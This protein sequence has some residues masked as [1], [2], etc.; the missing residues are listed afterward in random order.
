[1][2]KNS[3][4]MSVKRVRE[5][6]GF[7]YLDSSN[8]DES[9]VQGLNG[10]LKSLLM[11]HKNLVS[12]K[13]GILS[14]DNQI[15]NTIKQLYIPMKI[16][17][18]TLD[19]INKRVKEIL[20]G[21]TPSD[22][23]IFKLV[24]DTKVD[25]Y[26]VF[27]YLKVKDVDEFSNKDL[28]G[29]LN[30]D[31]DELIKDILTSDNSTSKSILEGVNKFQKSMVKFFNLSVI[32]AYN[33]ITTTRKNFNKEHEGKIFLDKWNILFKDLEIY[34]L[35]FLKEFGITKIITN[36]S[37]DYNPEIHLP[38]AEAEKDEELKNDQVK[39]VENEGFQF[40]NRLIFEDAETSNHILKQAEVIVVRNN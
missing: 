24:E 22:D 14:I 31:V 3:D 36:R 35:N 10:T 38:I 5:D 33:N 1:M 23:I 25:E 17:S 20:L 4:I 7:M 21:K 39:S 6:S 29:L 16:E 40:S 13:D 26:L 12:E 34:L 11:I 32:K 9:E 28:S 2:E 27:Q 37:D 15:N 18:V 8:L 19:L 30:N